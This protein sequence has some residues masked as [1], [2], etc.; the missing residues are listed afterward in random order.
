MTRL[1]AITLALLAGCAFPQV[2]QPLNLYDI[3]DG[4]TVELFFYPTSRDHGTISSSR[5]AEQEFHG[6]CSFSGEQGYP[7]PN[8]I[9]ENGEKFNAE[10]SQPPRD[11][12]EVYGF[13]KDIPAKP[14]G[15]GIIVGNKGKVIELVFYHLS[16]A[17]HSNDVETADGVGRDNKGRYYRIF[18]STRSE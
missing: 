13:S 7:R 15:S 10:N 16:W 1:A 17:A 6:E 18:L 5:N 4:T 9:L 14:V 12:A 8:H 3:D 2:I 11:F